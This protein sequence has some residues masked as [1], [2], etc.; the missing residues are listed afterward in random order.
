MVRKLYKCEIESCG[1]EVVIRSRIKSGEYKGKRVCS[2]CYNRI[3]EPLKP[4]KEKAEE[5]SKKMNR[6]SKSKPNTALDVYFEYHVERARKSEESN[7]AF[8]ATKANICH[9]LP[10]RRYKSVKAD[11]ENVVYLTIDEHTLFDHLLD[12]NDFEALEE[13]FPNCW[14]DVCSRASKV[15]RRTSE[16]G[17]LKTLWTEYLTDKGFFV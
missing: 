14:Y 12:C 6:G 11:L 16:N 1:N 3:L 4:S 9:L 5:Y 8:S 7:V 13:K 15:I 2:Y 17:K 10:K